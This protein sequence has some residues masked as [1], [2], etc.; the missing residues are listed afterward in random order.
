MTVRK[1]IRIRNLCGFCD[2]YN[3][4]LVSY[5][6]CII[7]DSITVIRG[8]Q[9]IKTMPFHGK[10]PS[11]AA[12]QQITQKNNNPATRRNFRCNGFCNSWVIWRD[13]FFHENCNQ[14]IKVIQFLHTENSSN[15]S[16]S[17]KVGKNKC[18]EKWPLVVAFPRNFFKNQ[19]L[20]CSLSW[21][22]APSLVTQVITV[23]HMEHTNIVWT[24][25]K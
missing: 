15:Y 5:T 17:I 8:N 7:N 22:L 25:S 19:E 11:A 12:K 20:K 21:L 10:N 1:I 4:Y 16:K 3:F 6:R 24:W 14:V 9:A 13:I 2:K 18:F 23:E